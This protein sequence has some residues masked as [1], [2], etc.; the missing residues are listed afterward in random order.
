MKLKALAIAKKSAWE[1][2]DKEDKDRG[3][4]EEGWFEAI[5]E[6]QMTLIPCNETLGID[7]KHNT[8]ERKIPWAVLLHK[9][10]V[11]SLYRQVA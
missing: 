1:A 9:E 3:E 2:E 11:S 5:R 7:Q 10:I 8:R 6:E 4:G